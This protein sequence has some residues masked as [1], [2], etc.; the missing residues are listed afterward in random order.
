MLFDR[1]KELDNLNFLLNESRPSLFDH[2]RATPFGKNDIAGQVGQDGQD[3]DPLLGSQPLFG[4]AV[5]A[6]LFASHL[7]RFD[8]P[9]CIID[10]GFSL[11]TWEMALPGQTGRVSPATGSVS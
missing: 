4:D 9:E 3:A 1:E 2:A 10:P 6:L 8:H 7:Y 11:P 5:A